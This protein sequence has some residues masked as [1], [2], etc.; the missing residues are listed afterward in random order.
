MVE[1]FGV[2]LFIDVY[3]IQLALYATL[4]SDDNGVYRVFPVLLV[5]AFTRVERI[6]TTPARGE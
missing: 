6:E 2:Y 4:C 5:L 1:G 3:D